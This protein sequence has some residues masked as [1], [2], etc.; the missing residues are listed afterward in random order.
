MNWNRLDWL[1]FNWSQWI[2]LESPIQVYQNHITKNPGLYRVRITHNRKLAYIGQTGRDL[3][4]RTRQLSSKVNNNQDN[5]PWNDPH[6]A[7]PALWAWKIENNYRYEVSV[8]AIDLETRERQCVEDMLLY[9]YR[10]EAKESTLANHGRCHPKWT[11]PGNRKSNNMMKKIQPGNNLSWG[12]SL[13]SVEEVGKPLDSNW[14]NLDWTEMNKLN[15]DLGYV[16]NESGVYR[17][18][19]TE[20]I[21]YIGETKNLHS[22]LISHAKK[23]DQF[24]LKFSCCEMKE[25]KPYHGTNLRCGS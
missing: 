9:E 18:L 17:L 6:T 11:R 15:K 24:S 14:L 16:P 23:Y 20:N 10:L 19:N 5:P 25:A 4:E 22:R 1:G 21:V 2:P 12:E 8:F 3:R 7:A 13:P